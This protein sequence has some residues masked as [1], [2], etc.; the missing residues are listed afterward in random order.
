M[1]KVEFKLHL[2]TWFN[3][4][5]YSS[6]KGYVSHGGAMLMMGL[7]EVSD[8]IDLNVGKETWDD[9]LS[10]GYKPKYINTPGLPP[11]TLISVTDHIDVHLVEDW[12]E[13]LNEDGVYYTT[14]EQ[15]V[16]DKQLLMRDKDIRDIVTLENYIRSRNV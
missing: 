5:G 4:M 8:D 14:P 7:R 2:L 3:K 6:T 16:K 10:L 15:T 9:I 13:L 1:D 11:V 12:P